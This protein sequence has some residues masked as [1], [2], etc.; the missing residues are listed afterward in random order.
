MPLVLGEPVSAPANFW[1]AQL[2]ALQSLLGTHW[3]A[4][5]RLVAIPITLMGCLVIGGMVLLWLRRERFI[6]LYFFVYV[7]VMCLTPWPNQFPRYLT[8]LTPFL[9][10]SLFYLL[11]S[12]AEWRSK[13]DSGW[14]RKASIALPVLLLAMI[15]FVQGLTLTQTVVRGRR[16]V[17]YYDAS[18]NEMKYPLF[19]Y[20]SQW[21]PVNTALEWL[22]WRSKSGEVIAATAPHSAYLRTKLKAVLPPLEADSELAQRLLDSVPVKYV[23]LD[24]LGLPGIS[25]RYAAPTIVKHP[26][27]WTLIYV[28]P[29]GGARIYERVQ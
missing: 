4:P 21:E 10:L 12:V 5:Q 22:R 11:A 29:G 23:V 1:R 7:L 8:P 13:Q 14:S 19:Y 15:F 26:Q 6:P 28:A 2:G 17:T 27:L 18:G 9:A 25:E 3:E 24:S 20:D 16:L